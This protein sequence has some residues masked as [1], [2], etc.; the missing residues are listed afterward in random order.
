MFLKIHIIFFYYH[1]RSTQYRTR[2]SILL[3]AHT[4][5]AVL[6]FYFPQITG[7]YLQFRPFERFTLGFRIDY[8]F[9]T[10]TK[11]RTFDTCHAVWNSKACKPDISIECSI[12][13]SFYI[14]FQSNFSSHTVLKITF[15]IIF[16]IF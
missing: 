11:H 5:K 4:L 14:S 3:T 8:Q 15:V 16:V 1:T 10:I 9:N 2:Y 7:D 6:K 12:V 13:D